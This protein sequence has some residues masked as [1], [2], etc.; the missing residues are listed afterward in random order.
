MSR[1]KI[2][3]IVCFTVTFAAGGAAGLLV[4]SIGKGKRG[5]HGHSWLMDQ[6]DLSESQRGQ[7]REIWSKAG[8]GSGKSYWDRRR[9]LGEARDKAVG[10]MVSPEQKERFEA[11][12]K[13]YA[14]KL[15]ELSDQRKKEYDQ[16]VERTKQIL[17]PE[18]GPKYDELMKRQRERG[19]GGRPGGRHAGETDAGGQ[20]VSSRPTT[21]QSRDGRGGQ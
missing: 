2:L 19:Y 11:I 12:M 16:A 14:D 15:K 9:A 21:D 5:G 6:L 18:Q 4:G 20:G 13:D 1:S 10:D 3:L 7:M 17:T 8:E